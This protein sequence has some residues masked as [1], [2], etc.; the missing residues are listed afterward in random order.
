MPAVGKTKQHLFRSCFGG[1]KDRSNEKSPE[2]LQ[3]YLPKQLLFVVRQD[4]GDTLAD[5]GQV[6]AF[7]EEFHF[8]EFGHVAMGCCGAGEETV[9]PGKI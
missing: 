2:F 8:G 4:G 5:G 1:N 3:V 6:P 7:A 9:K